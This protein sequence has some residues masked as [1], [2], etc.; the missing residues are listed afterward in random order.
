MNPL[1]ESSS[2]FEIYK[3]LFE[4]NH[5]ACYALDWEGN[6]LLFNDAAVEIT[7][8]SKEEVIKKSFIPLVKEDC[9]EKTIRYFDSVLQGNSKKF[10]ASIKHKSGKIVDLNVTAA[11]IYIDGHIY[12]IVGTARD[13]TKMNNQEKL[14]NGQNDI[15]E[16]L[17]K[18]CPF[19]DILDRIIY[20]VEEFSNGGKCSILIVN[21]SG[22]KLV[23]G[24]A[25]NLPAKY[26]ERMNGIPIGPTAGFCG[27]A[28]YY[29]RPIIVSDIVNDP[30]WEDYQETALQ[31]GLRSCWSSP[32]CDNQQKVLGVFTMYHDKPRFP[33]EEDMKLIEKA[34]HLTSLVVQHSQTEE[35]INFM[36]S[37]DELTKLPNRRLFNEKVNRAIRK[38]KIAQ[39]QMLG[40]MFLDLDR[41]KLI[42]D[43]LGHSVGDV[44]L[45]SVGQ[46]LQRCIRKK[47]TV[48]RQGGDEFTI[49]VNDISKNEANLIAQRILNELSKPYF[50]KGQEIFITPSI[51]ISLYPLD[52]ENA[53]ELLR[54][55][56]V[57]MYQ[58]KNEGR[59]G[60]QFYHSKFDK[61]TY[62]RLE[63]ENEL[64]KALDNNEFTLHYQ[65]IIDLATN[66]VSGVEALIRWAH[67]K[68]G[69]VSPN[70]FIPIAE[71]TGMIVSIGEWVL[72]T[73]CRQLKKMQS[74]GLISMVSINISFR[75]FYQPNLTF[76][77]KQILK[78]TGIDPQN[79]TIEITESMTMDVE[80]ASTILY[81]LKNLGV[82]ISIDDFGTGYS[83]L[84]YL[85]KFPIDYLKIDQSFIRD[86]AKSNYDRNIVTTIILMARNLGV[87][88]IAEG[89][90]TSEQLEFLRQY[91]CNEAQGYIFSK[92]LSA[93]ELK[94]FLAEPP[95]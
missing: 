46:R 75:Q 57:A 91:N 27:T 22:R 24:S 61:M 70:R 31:Y 67:P 71:E 8:Y 11:P 15:L 23:L 14:L 20:L 30:L 77:V 36:A 86:I 13:V 92:P 60:F 73:A 40:L 87:G 93:E 39:D 28:A 83:S 44:L 94:Q 79:I 48:S 42:N 66:K 85:K 6:F 17:A 56:D 35:K 16:M 95:S 21:E 58:A 59:N 3:S 90:E 5:D 49:L 7:G 10:C 63:L 4:Y 68:F 50:I 41:F 82:K 54:K 53:D 88:V 32:V 33:N 72:Q 80:S 2:Q 65:P 62:D 12:G 45:K 29:N 34:I 74:D 69:F 84:N 1:I 9:L 25:P 18:G 43:T 81:D 26:S 89:V 55:A 76:V 64:R 37:H 38:N 51:G 19:S 78:E 52:G 47:D